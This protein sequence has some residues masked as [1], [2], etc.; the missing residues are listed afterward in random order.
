MQPKAKLYRYRATS[1]EAVFESRNCLFIL[2]LNWLMQGVRGMDIQEFSFRLLLET[3]LA[4]LVACLASV[5]MGM[6]PLSAAAC[7][8][9]IA[10]TIN[11]LVNGQFW[12]CLRYCR[13]YRRQTRTLARQLQTLL[14]R[15]AG[16]PWLAE[17][18]LLGSTVTQ[19]DRPGP[20]ADVDLRL[21]FPAGLKGWF[22]TN[23]LLLELRAWAFWQGLPLDVYAYA[24]PASLRRFDQREPLGILLDRA[25]RLR[26]GFANRQLVWLR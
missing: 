1:P 14:S 21:I 7:G 22:L 15:V 23:C 24:H 16:R 19:L 2:S 11:F 4:I 5:G 3:A 13:F 12:V 8:L 20:R 18:V 26:R 17:A 6:E 10:H 9:A 25:S